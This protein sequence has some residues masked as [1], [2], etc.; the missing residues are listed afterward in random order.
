MCQLPVILAVKVSVASSGLAPGWAAHFHLHPAFVLLTVVLHG[1]TVVIAVLPVI[2]YVVDAFGPDYSAS[3]LTALLITR[4]LM[5]TF[6]PL[7]TAPLTE[8]LGWGWGFTV[9]A[10]LSALLAPI[11]GVV[12]WFGRGWRARSEFTNEGGEG[13]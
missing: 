1:L 9:L 2:S 10:G 8:K 12:M 13:V 5:G 11:P 6:L 3:S 4:C 7:A